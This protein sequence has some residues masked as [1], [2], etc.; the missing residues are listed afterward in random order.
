MAQDYRITNQRQTTALS[1][2]G[3]FQDVIEV[4]FETTHGTV[5]SVRVTVAIYSADNVAKAVQD[6]VDQLNAVAQL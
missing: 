5:G 1:S 4:T 2:A 6:R 3:Q